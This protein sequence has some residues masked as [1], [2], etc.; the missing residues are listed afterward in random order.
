MNENMSSKTNFTIEEQVLN[1]LLF[2][3]MSIILEVYVG[4]NFT[5][6]N[7]NHFIDVH[8]KALKKLKLCNFIFLCKLKKCSAPEKNSREI[9]ECQSGTYRVVKI[10]RTVLKGS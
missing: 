6:K 3:M 2:N 1:E 8:S 5:I 9:E 7:A 10:K 4:K